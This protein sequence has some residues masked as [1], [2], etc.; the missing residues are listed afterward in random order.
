VISYF[1]TFTKD[2]KGDN[3][4]IYASKNSNLESL[5]VLLS[6]GIDI[7]SQNLE[8]KTALMSAAEKSNFLILELL[9]L[10]DAN[11]NVIDKSGLNVL[12]QI[13]L[14]PFFSD[15]EVIKL[16]ISKGAN[17]NIS[18]KNEGYTPLLIASKNGNEELVKLLI[19]KGANINATLKIGEYKGYNA[20]FLAAS[21][22]HKNIVNIFLSK[23]LRYNKQQLN[24]TL[25]KGNMI[26]LQRM[27][28]TYAVDWGGV[29]PSSIELL[30]QEAKEKSYYL[31]IKNPIDDNLASLVNY[32]DY[33]NKK[34]P[35]FSV[36]YMPKNNSEYAISEYKVFASDDNS[37]LLKDSFGQDF[38]LT[39]N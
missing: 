1:F 39:N 2:E 14:N 6:S 12:M 28:E 23:K 27:L 4:L 33:I 17:I 35:Y 8:G 3:A 13:M 15:N 34:Y 16:L 19:S 31:E 18:S 10:K 32:N 24:N 9:L 7:N 5:A 38:Y 22:G 36:I 11:V 21:E 20:M 25:L 26:K 29:Y 30:E 37:N